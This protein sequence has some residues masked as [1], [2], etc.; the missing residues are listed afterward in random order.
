MSCSRVEFCVPFLCGDVMCALKAS[1][2]R[3]VNCAMAVWI[4]LCCWLVQ[5]L[6]TDKNGRTTSGNRYGHISLVC[7]VD[8][9]VCAKLGRWANRFGIRVGTL[10]SHVDM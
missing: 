6:I 8:M 2:L 4:P 9:L 5:Q 1:L 7:T 3:L 10:R